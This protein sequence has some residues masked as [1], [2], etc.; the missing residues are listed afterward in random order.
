TLLLYC[1]AAGALATDGNNIAPLTP[2]VLTPPPNY[3]LAT[4]EPN[5]VMTDERRGRSWVGPEG[6]G[7]YWKSPVIYRQAFQ[8]TQPIRRIELGTFQG[9]SSEVGSPANAFIYVNVPDGR[10]FYIGDAAVTASTA[11]GSQTL[12]FDFTPV[13][14]TSVLI[15]I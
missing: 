14:A 6:V 5:K 8:T 13:A 10:W 4:G 15:V 7:W 12:G 1:S 11:D 2:Y 3:E 9:L